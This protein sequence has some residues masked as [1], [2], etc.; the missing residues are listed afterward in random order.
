MINASEPA[1]INIHQPMEMRYA[2]SCSHLCMKYQAKGEAINNAIVTSFRKSFDSKTL[3]LVADPPPAFLIPF[4]FVLYSAASAAK[5]NK[6]RHARKMEIPP[7]HPM[8]LLH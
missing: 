3:M 2:K 1:T 4:F 8:M 6:P 7:A 5:P